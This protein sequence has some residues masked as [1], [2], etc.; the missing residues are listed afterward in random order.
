M[1]L[2]RKRSFY[3]VIA[4]LLMFGAALALVF[5]DTVE[6]AFLR[7]NSL[8]PQIWEGTW[9]QASLAPIFGHGLTSDI[10]LI[11][12]GDV[13]ETTHNAYLQAFWHGGIIGLGLLL[14]LLLIAF[15]QSLSLGHRG[16]DYTVFC[17]LLFVAATMMT[18]VDTLIDRP[19]DKWMLF[20]LPLALLL[21]YRTLAPPRRV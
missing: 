12:N 15:R 14:L 19:R 4:A 18:G 8:R 1:T 5:P 3:T 17:M 21:S 16:G 6:Q 9:S 20:W 13:I 10:F 2:K 7:G 11:V